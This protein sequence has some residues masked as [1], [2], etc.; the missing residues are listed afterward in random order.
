MFYLFNEYVQFLNRVYDITWFWDSLRLINSETVYEKRKLF[1]TRLYN[2]SITC[3]KIE[4]INYNLICTTKFT[5][6]S[7]LITI[8]S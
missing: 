2:A 4:H 1:Q 7:S 3:S 8:I 6:S 5:D